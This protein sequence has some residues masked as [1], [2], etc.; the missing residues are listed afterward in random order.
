MFIM[1]SLG[2]FLRRIK[3]VDEH[4]LNKMNKVCF[5]AFLAV[6]VYYNIYKVDIAQVFNGR[7]LCYAVVTQFVIVGISL[8]VATMTEK[9]KKRKGA[10]SHG[11]FHTNFVIFGTLIGTALCGEGNIGAISLLIAIIVPLQNVLSVIVLELY[12]EGGSLSFK[13]T[14]SGV[15]TNPYVVAAILGF[16]T[17]TL[18][19]HYP[20]MIANVFRDLG[21]CGTP[22]ALIIMGGL[23]NFGAVKN[24][25]K[26]IFIGTLFRLLIIPAIM[27][28][29]TIALGFRGPDFI[30]LMCIFIAPCATTSFNLASAMDSDADLAAQLVVF[31][32]LCSLGTIFMWIYVLSRMGIF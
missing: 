26:P 31:T 17:Q 9:T 6:S 23:F 1:L 30:S 7:L 18:H 5:R 27:I 12:R 13:K 11:I 16:L 3:M 24:N 14:F 22:V 4:T 29:I 19:I 15:M 25:L 32:S 10:L 20:E 2:V 8:L 28:S 21:R